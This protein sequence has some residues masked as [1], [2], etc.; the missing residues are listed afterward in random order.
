MMY[1]ILT[2]AEIMNVCVIL[3]IFTINEENEV[4]SI[5]FWYHRKNKYVI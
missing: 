3:S 4:Y 5:G 1:M 2:N